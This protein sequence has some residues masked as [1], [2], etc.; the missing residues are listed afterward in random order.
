[1]LD[2]YYIGEK[3]NNHLIQEIF[4]IF[5]QNNMKFLKMNIN[6]TPIKIVSENL[7]NFPY[8]KKIPK[9]L[10]YGISLQPAI[11]NKEY[12]LNILGDQDYSAWEF[13]KKQLMNVDFNSK[14]YIKDCYLDFRNILNI[15]NFVIKGY[16]VRKEYNYFK[17][18]YIFQS[19][20]ERKKMPL[21]IAFKKDIYKFLFNF[22]TN[23]R[24]LRKFLERINIHV[25]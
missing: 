4:E 20:F 10:E 12:F 9:A 6:S 21:F 11:W 5:I 8:I 16:I 24:L 7:V 2:D 13:E 18:N 19:G 25:Y 17:K 3:V 1:M 23:H 15:H 14:E 22:V